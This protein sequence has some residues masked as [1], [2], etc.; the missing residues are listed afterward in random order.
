M[1]SDKNNDMFKL[2]IASPERSKEIILE[3]HYSP[4]QIFNVDKTELFWKGISL[5][6]Y[7]SQ[8]KS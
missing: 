7:I 6:M 2:L 4:K 1:K 5:Q 3:G 8:Y